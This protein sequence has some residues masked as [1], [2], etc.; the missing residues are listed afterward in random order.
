MA[1]Y[2]AELGYLAS[3][4][5]THVQSAEQH[6]QAVNSMA[7]VSARYAI[8]AVEVL[9]MLLSA[10]LYC[11]CMAVDLRVV[12]LC[13]R[14]RLADST[15]S[16]LSA[17]FSSSL[18]RAAIDGLSVAVLASVYR[19]LERSASM[20]S[21]YRFV[22]A[23]NCAASVVVDALSS[24]DRGLEGLR[25]L[26]AWKKEAAGQAAE[27]YVRTRDEFFDGSV[28]PSLAYLGK[29]GALY[30]F[31]R[32]DLDV[33]P[34]RGDVKCGGHQGEPV[35]P[36]PDET[37]TGRRKAAIGSDVSKIH[38]AIRSGKLNPVLARLFS[39]L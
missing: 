28:A 38:F 24:T 21:W 31:V 34:R 37:L 2:T 32:Q 12:D 9:S 30:A 25:N 18:D 11:V 3:S 17:H 26:A 7:L 22:D 15:P 36:P 29:T 23:F 20:D 27:L 14:Q 4:V 13:F 16:L 35:A 5:T 6:N 1:A 8:Q 39:S 10:Q 19:T 33:K